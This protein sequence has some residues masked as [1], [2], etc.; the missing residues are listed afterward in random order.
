MPKTVPDD[1]ALSAMF[2]YLLP[3]YDTKKDEK[4]VRKWGVFFAL[5]SLA[6]ER[7]DHHP[8]TEESADEQVAKNKELAKVYLK[9]HKSGEFSALL[10]QVAGLTSHQLEVAFE[11]LR[12]NQ[13]YKQR[14]DTLEI[15]RL[16]INVINDDYAAVKQ[17]LEKHAEDGYW[18]SETNKEAHA[19]ARLLRKAVKNKN[20]Q[21]LALLLKYGIPD[22]EDKHGLSAED[23]AGGSR[24]PQIQVSTMS[25]FNKEGLLGDSAC[26]S[27]FGLM[28]ADNPDIKK[29]PALFVIEDYLRLEWQRLGSR[30]AYK[31]NPRY[32]QA[33]TR[34]KALDKLGVKL[35]QFLEILS[36][37]D[38]NPHPKQAVTEYITDN[39]KK[40]KENS[41]F[42][43]AVKVLAAFD[44]EELKSNFKVFSDE[45][46]AKYGETFQEDSRKSWFFEELVI[47]Q[48]K[49]NGK[50]VQ[51]N[52]NQYTLA[53]WRPK[54][55]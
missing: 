13:K 30:E 44:D 22:K 45:H 4:A 31:Q 26:L 7:Q 27:V 49:E 11:V 33:L 41:A 55:D 16:K 23:L 46:Q 12:D 53:G 50:G 24:G 38:T 19:N 18:T 54:P 39:F 47:A 36:L 34:D 29:H 17:L 37:I 48:I 6:D 28:G 1:Q 25:L 9:A 42:R 5:F 15:Q 20:P 52:D 3:H 35:N 43:R 32:F 40:E 51:R 8:F 10:K 2:N 14:Q 21:M